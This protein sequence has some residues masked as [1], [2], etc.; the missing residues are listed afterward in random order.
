MEEEFEVLGIAEVLD[1]SKVM[2]YTMVDETF[3]NYMH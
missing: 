1:L 2:G 3:E